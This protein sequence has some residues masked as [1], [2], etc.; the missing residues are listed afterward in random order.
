MRVGRHKRF[1]VD[2]VVA[3]GLSSGFIEPLE[4]NGL[5]TVHENLKSLVKVLKRGKPS[6]FAKNIFNDDMRLIFDEFA[7]FVAA[8]YALS[9]RQDS[10]YWRD[11]FNKDYDVEKLDGK[12]G[13]KLYGREFFRFGAYQRPDKGFHYIANG[14]NFNPTLSSDFNENDIRLFAQQKNQWKSRIRSLPT[15][16]EY[17]SKY[18]HK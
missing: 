16:Y 17:L 14:M 4:S 7:D 3:I 2:N 13:L 11:N 6:Q 5:F 8:H 18:V 10:Q 1:W 12:Y 15:M 9:Q